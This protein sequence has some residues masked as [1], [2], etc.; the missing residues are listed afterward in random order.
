MGQ[1][2]SSKEPLPAVGFLVG[3]FHS[4][5]LYTLPLFAPHCMYH[6]SQFHVPPRHIV[7]AGHCYDHAASGLTPV[8]RTRKTVT[9]VSDMGSDP[10]VRAQPS[11]K[12]KL[13]CFLWE[14]R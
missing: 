7:I 8:L 6:S 11:R 4:L 9:Q 13:G 10:L 5:L 2:A 12:K 3:L 1:P 14:D